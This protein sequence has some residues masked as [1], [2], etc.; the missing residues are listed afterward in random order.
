MQRTWSDDPGY[1]D[2]EGVIYHYPQRYF[3]Y[4]EGYERFV[5]Y[6]PAKGAAPGEASSYVGYGTLGE[7]FPDP[8]DPSH[9]FV[10][11]RQYRPFPI[12]VRF[13]NATGQFFESTFSSRTAFTG[14][15]VRRI[16]PTDYFRILSAA[17][18]YGEPFRDL[19]DTQEIVSR[20]YSPIPNL[21]APTQP[22][23]I[24]DRIP[25]GTGYRPTGN[26]IDALE[27]AALQERARRDHQDVLR[28]LQ[29]IVHERGGETFLNNNVDLY[30]NVRG[31]RLLIEAKSINHSRVVVDRM[32]YGIGQLVDYGIRYRA[33][34]GG[35]E[36]VL[37]FGM[38]PPPESAW[39]SSILQE[40]G[41][42]FVALDESVNRIVP[43][44]ERARSLP[45]FQSL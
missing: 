7:P 44:N 14:R 32:R 1:L 16:L 39:V 24:V 26:P 35:A 25:P 31:K 4:I 8:D 15:S 22:L 37:A 41:I 36:R 34:L 27:S 12:S 10:A 21:V 19:A 23:R 20:P 33:E 17:G 11:I 42:S 28:R 30:A 38:V 9:R 6:R 5:Y 43:L 3:A 45:L 2:V 13:L 40:T 18:I 29:Q